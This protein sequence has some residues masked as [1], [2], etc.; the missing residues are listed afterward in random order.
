MELKLWS[1]LWDLDR[2]WHLDFPRFI[3]ETTGFR[4]LVDVVKT[5]G[6]LIMT[7]EL[8][9]MDPDDVDISLDGGVLVVK[10]DKTEEREVTEE[11]R[12]VHE[13]SFGAFQRRIAVPDGVTADAIDATFDNGLLTVKVKLPEEKAVEPRKIPVGTKA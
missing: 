3:R 1:P 2:E 5:D 4:P 9:G 10:G 11:D 12:Y 7:A 6:Q 8:P 13:R